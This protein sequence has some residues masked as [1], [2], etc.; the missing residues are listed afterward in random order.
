MAQTS[1]LLHARLKCRKC[2]EFLEAYLLSIDK[3][4]EA[5]AA[6]HQEMEKHLATACAWTGDEEG[7]PNG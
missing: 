5:H 7:K 1:P 3:V 4:P 2:G 6:M